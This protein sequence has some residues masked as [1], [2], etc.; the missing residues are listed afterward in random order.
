MLIKKKLAKNNVYIH[1]VE[2]CPHHPD[3]LV[4]KLSIKCKC[5]KPSN[6][7]IKKIERKWFVNMKKSYFIGDKVSD[8]LAAKKS[9]LK[10]HYAQNDILKQ[11]KKMI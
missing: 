3:G 5:R 7:M 1:D 2:F 6:L 9:K 4:K 8:E 11:V 10:F